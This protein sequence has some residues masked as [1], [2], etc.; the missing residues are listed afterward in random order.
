MKGYLQNFHVIAI[1]VMNVYLNLVSRAWVHQQRFNWPISPETSTHLEEEFTPIPRLEETKK[2]QTKTKT[3]PT[4]PR[5][6]RKEPQTTV[7]SH[8]SCLS[9]YMCTIYQEVLIKQ[10]NANSS[11]TNVL[12]NNYIKIN[13]PE[14]WVLGRKQNNF[15]QLLSKM[16]L[17]SRVWFKS[18]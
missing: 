7:E 10:R 9:S 4:K 1:A 13:L 2:T 3:K 11:V 18:Y 16:C 14:S 5:K 12:K 15:W 6:L 8:D 17:T